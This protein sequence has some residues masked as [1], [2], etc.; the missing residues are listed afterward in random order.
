[1]TSPTSLRRSPSPTGY[2]P[3]LYSRPS[4][5]RRPSSSSSSASSTSSDSSYDSVRQAKED[6]AQWEESMR[7]LW[8]LFHVVALPFGAKWVG[9]KVAYWGQSSLPELTG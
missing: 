3:P 1:M 6:Q 7:Q 8:L 2:L 9:R 4:F 5:D